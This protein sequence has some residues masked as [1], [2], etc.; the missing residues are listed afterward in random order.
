M[1]KFR[2]ALMRAAKQG[3]HEGKLSAAECYCLMDISRRPIRILNRKRLVKESALK[4]GEELAVAKLKMYDPDGVVSGDIDW[5][6][7]IDLLIEWGPAIIRAVLLVIVFF[8]E[9]PK[10]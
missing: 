6:H 4:V 3:Y 9:P 2:S 10:K 8:E 7:W 5:S 1:L